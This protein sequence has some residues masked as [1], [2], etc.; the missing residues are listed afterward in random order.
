MKNS[1]QQSSKAT[2]YSTV[3]ATLLRDSS[4]SHRPRRLPLSRS[5]GVTPITRSVVRV[6]ESCPIALLVLARFS[7]SS[8]FRSIHVVERQSEKTSRDTCVITFLLLAKIARLSSRIVTNKWSITLRA[9]IE[10]DPQ[11]N[12]H[13]VLDFTLS[14]I[15]VSSRKRNIKR[16]YYEIIIRKR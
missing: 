8:Y 15:N 3:I 1:K 7:T 12:E 9:I 14:T 5:N 16:E 13:G 10:S 11:L 6:S 4:R 2:T